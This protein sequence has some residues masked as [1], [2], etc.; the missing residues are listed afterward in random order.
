MFAP[1]PSPGSEGLCNIKQG[2]SLSGPF[3]WVM[4]WRIQMGRSSR[5]C[6]WRS[7]RRTEG[8]PAWQRLEPEQCLSPH[9]DLA[10]SKSLLQNPEMT[11]E[12]P[13]PLPA[14]E[15]QGELAE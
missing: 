14:L 12:S 15:G 2:L 6:S 5:E 13:L 10:V 7:Q 9:C 1:K 8:P 11:H 4:G 3:Q